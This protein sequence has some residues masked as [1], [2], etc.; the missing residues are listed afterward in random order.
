MQAGAS[1]SALLMLSI[2]TPTPPTHP[3]QD[4][5]LGEKRTC[6]GGEAGCQETCTWAGPGRESRCPEL[7]FKLGEELGA[8]VTREVFCFPHCQ[9]LAKGGAGAAASYQLGGRGA[10]PRLAALP[11]SPWGPLKSWSQL[12]TRHEGLHMQFSSA[13]QGPFPPPCCPRASDPQGYGRQSWGWVGG[14]HSNVSPLP[15]MEVGSG[16]V[17]II[18]LSRH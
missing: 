16:H 11:G 7:A 12:Q 8:R 10:P 1:S 4:S 15:Q 2:L 6:P 9:A 17:E 14:N 18:A 5:A 13:P 3:D